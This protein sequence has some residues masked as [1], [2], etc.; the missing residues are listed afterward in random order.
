MCHITKS[1]TGEVYVT[2][3]GKQLTRSAHLWL[4]SKRICNFFIK[5][6]GESRSQA[7]AMSI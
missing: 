7:I 5:A 2:S 3:Q 6:P 4:Y 1:K